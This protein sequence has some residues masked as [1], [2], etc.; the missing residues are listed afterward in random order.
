MG[1]P[2]TVNMGAGQAK[3]IV[4][5]SPGDTAVGQVSEAI[6]NSI[7]NGLEC[8]EYDYAFDAEM[9]GLI[10]YFGEF[11]EAYGDDM[12]LSDIAEQADSIVDDETGETYVIGICNS[13][14]DDEGWD[15]DECPDAITGEQKQ[16]KYF[17]ELDFTGDGFVEMSVEIE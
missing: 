17:Q 11:W 13:W 3:L 14:E 1:T 6:S 7:K 5:L 15:D 8:D 16:I 2:Q 12:L 10:P 4:F 9:T